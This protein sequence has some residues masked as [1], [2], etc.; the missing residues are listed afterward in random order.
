MATFNY[1]DE[2]NAEALARSADRA[3]QVLLPWTQLGKWYVSFASQFA[4][5]LEAS[6][7]SELAFAGEITALALSCVEAIDFS[8]VGARN[9][10]AIVEEAIML[11]D[12]HR[13][14]NPDHHQSYLAAMLELAKGCHDNA[15]TTLLAFRD[16]RVNVFKVCR[17]FLC[18]PLVLT[19]SGQLL[20]SVTHAYEMVMSEFSIHN[21][22]QSMSGSLH[23]YCYTHSLQ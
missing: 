15:N 19:C 11:G 10:F 12:L 9:G 1:P 18:F 20:K 6:Y 22:G 7:S 2:F 3:L 14:S 21:N 8:V 23:L 17:L 16:L 13:N 4:N 5:F